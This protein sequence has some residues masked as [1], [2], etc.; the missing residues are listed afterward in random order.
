[1]TSRN[2]ATADTVYMNGRIYTV[3][4]NQ[5]WVQAVAI[6][7]G[8][9]LAVGTDEQIQAT[10][11]KQT[12]V[13]DLAGRMAMPGLHD[14]HCHIYH[15]GLHSFLEYPFQDPASPETIVNELKQRADQSGTHQGWLI[16]GVYNP[17][18]FPGGQP[19]R[20]FLDQAFPDTAVLLTEHSANKGLANAKT[21]AL[22]GIGGDTPAPKGGEIIRDAATGEPTG[23]LIEEAYYLV[24]S[25]VPEYSLAQYLDTVKRTQTVCNRYGIV[26][27][28]DVAAPE[29]VLNILKV[30]DYFGEL[31]L[32]VHAALIWRPSEGNIPWFAFGTLQDQ[33]DLIRSRTQYTSKNLSVNQVKVWLDGNPMPPSTDALIDP[34]TGEIDTSRLLISEEKLTTLLIW[35]EKQNIPIKMHATGDGAARTA[36]NAVEA[37]KKEHPSMLRHEIAHSF[38][39][40]R[41]DLSR[42]K[43]LRVTAEFCPAMLWSSKE[44]VFAKDAAKCKFR[45]TLASGALVTAGTDWAT[46]N[47]S[48]ALFPGIGGMLDLGDESVDLPTAIAIHTINGARAV[49]RCES[50]G[51]IEPLKRANMIVLD[52]NLFEVTIEEI[53]QT[54]VLR[55]IFDGRI[56]FDNL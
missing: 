43:D 22:A 20:A 21:L 48:P 23:H 47:I 36:L 29:P 33:E 56:A 25:K 39:I 2:T 14:A 40:H 34:L 7:K 16:A 27:V 1:M 3:D 11:G 17:D 8:H 32:S 54:Q 15:A 35:L 24:R 49:G 28:Q 30:L 45:S 42:L 51:S 6:R 13:V 38:S 41:D 37:A 44:E 10:I 12:Q 31:T 55:T 19:T 9:F 4:P 5:P 50:E 53:K 46:P 26:S 18:I 52:R